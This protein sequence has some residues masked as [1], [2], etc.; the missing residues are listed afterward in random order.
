MT[1][2]RGDDMEYINGNY[3]IFIENCIMFAAR[4]GMAQGIDMICNE[5]GVV[6]GGMTGKIIK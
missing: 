4:T 3:K 1:S 6:V 5:L 2:K